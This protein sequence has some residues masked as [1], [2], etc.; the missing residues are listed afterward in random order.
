MKVADL[1]CNGMQIMK[2]P[3]R[4]ELTR[5]RNDDETDRGRKEHILR[6]DG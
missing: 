4:D 1:V 3:R 2:W 5:V 6:M